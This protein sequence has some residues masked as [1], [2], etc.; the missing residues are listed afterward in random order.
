VIQAELVG[1]TTAAER[2]SFELL[3]DL[4]RLLPSEGPGGVRVMVVDGKPGVAEFRPGAGEV[5]VSR[6]ALRRVVDVAGAAREQ[7]STVRDR[8][9]RV[10]SAENPLVQEGE[11][12]S[13]PIRA[14][15]EA[16]YQVIVTAAG[17]A[18]VARIGAWPDGRS[19]AAAF[20]HDLDVVARWPLFAALRW[21]ELLGKGEVGRALSAMA[22]AAGSALGSPVR[23]GVE[24]MLAVEQHAGVRATWFVLAGE[25][26][27]ES[28]RRGD[29]TYRL[30]DPAPRRLVELMTRAGHEVGLHGSFATWDSAERMGEERHRVAQ[31]TGVAPAGVRQH[32]LRFDPGITPGVAAGAGFRYDAT[33]GFADRTGFRLGLADVVP[34]WHAAGGRPV[35]LL[36]APLIWM[37]RA[38]S[39]YQGEEDPE[40]WVADALTLAEDCR[41]SGGLWVGLWHPNVI[42]ALGF[43]GALG[44]F[45]QLVQRLA[46]WSPYI[47]PLADLVEWR[48]ARRGLRVRQSADGGVQLTSN[49]PG[50]WRIQ[51]S[52]HPGEPPITYPWPEVRRG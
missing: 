29:V 9:G 27:S 13:Q 7:Q 11:A 4:A 6:A 37:D 12:R 48:A 38:L 51:L 31:V 42:P 23:A 52:L 19:W 15:A 32:F 49:R 28:W 21:G 18:P 3:V 41:A 36:E 39:K 16:L 43:P 20:T 26:T 30:E 44:A 34:L 24:A 50:N 33:L 8:F 17:N 45:A 25:P 1:E 40:R 35:N 47:A 5:Q 14:L 22:S 2:W 46:G 10:P